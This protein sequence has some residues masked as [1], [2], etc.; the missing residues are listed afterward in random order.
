MRIAA[1]TDSPLADERRHDRRRRV[2]RRGRRA[3][4][5]RRHAPAPA[6]PRRGAPRLQAPRGR[7]RGGPPLRSSSGSAR[8]TR[9]TPSAR[10]SP[11]PPC[12]AARASWA[13]TTLCWEVPH[14]VDDA[15]VAGLVEGTRAGRL[16]LRPLPQPPRGR[17]RAR[18]AAAQRAPRRERAGRRS[19]RSSPRRRTARATCRTCPATRRRRRSSPQ[20]AHE[21]AGEADG[22]A[23]EVLGEQEIRERGM[24]A[25]AAVAQGS[26]AGGA[27]DR[28][29]RYEGRGRADGPL[30]A[31]VGKAVTFDSGGISL[32]PGARMSEM[33]FDMSGG[34]AVLEAV[35]A[36]AR[37]RA[38]DPRARD[39]RRDRE[40]A[41]RRAP[42]SPATSCARRTARRSRSSTPTPRAGSCWPTASRTRSRTAPSG[43]STSRR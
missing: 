21:L 12:T 2:R 7:A 37:L 40:H 36:I 33:K 3:R 19:G 41:E 9:S 1:T 16:P 28:A 30:L 10:G 24:G 20:R 32:K 11:P 29:C 26:D 8:A 25:F 17:R 34:A 4:R 39:R 18:G 13:P 27:A 43:S 6:R 22:I 42:S 38:A 15:V 31:L 14:H 35:G 23:V 5:R